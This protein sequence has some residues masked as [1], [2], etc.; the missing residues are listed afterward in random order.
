MAMISHHHQAVFVHIPK[1]GGQ[2]IETLFLDDLGLDWSTRAPLLLRP[3]DDPAKG[4]P[5][6]AHLLASEYVSLGHIS[7]E[8]FARYYKFALVRDPYDRA[9]S[10]FNYLQTGLDLDR[11][12]LDWLP[13]QFTLRPSYLG[14]PHAYP[15]KFHFVRPQADFVLG[16]DRELLVDELFRL[17]HVEG[18]TQRIL[19]RCEFSAQLRHVNRSRKVQARR[20]DLRADHVAMINRL[21]E[22]DFA[23]LDYAMHE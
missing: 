7:G 19:A 21:Y 8:L 1:C 20:T 13:A 10:F 4:P 3:N 22:E 11:F 9:L 12:M 18:A 5:R 23:L 14:H 17:E 16:E 15:G 6:L 2:S